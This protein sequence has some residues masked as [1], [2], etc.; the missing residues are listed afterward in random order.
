VVSDDPHATV[1]RNTATLDLRMSNLHRTGE[2][3]NTLLGRNRLP[4]E[5]VYGNEDVG[6]VEPQDGA[7]DFE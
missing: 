5:V 4:A 1:N 6:L 3:D 2:R 7:H